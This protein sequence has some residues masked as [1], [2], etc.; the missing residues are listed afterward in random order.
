MNSKKNSQSQVE[1][2]FYL[3]AGSADQESRRVDFNIFWSW[4]SKKK[5]FY[6]AEPFRKKVLKFLATMIS[7]DMHTQYHQSFW[8]TLESINSQGFRILFLLQGRHYVNK[9]HSN[10]LFKLNSFHNFTMNLKMISFDYR[11]TNKFLHYLAKGITRNLFNLK[12][13]ELTFFD[14]GLT[15]SGIELFSSLICPK[16][17][18][19]EQLTL[20][21]WK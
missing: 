17:R 11:V 10:K 3:W 19:L 15:D 12:R 1:R 14:C 21:F 4:S 7:W 6:S 2:L 13:L 9:K 8:R 18:Q 16:L 20:R 5:L